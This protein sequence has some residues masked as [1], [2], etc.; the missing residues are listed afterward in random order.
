MPFVKVNVYKKVTNVIRLISHLF[1]CVLLSHFQVTCIDI[2]CLHQKNNKTV[3]IDFWT[4]DVY[5]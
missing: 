5:I 3:G 1:S 2:L 4:Y